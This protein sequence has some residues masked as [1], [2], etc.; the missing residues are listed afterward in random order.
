[1]AVRWVGVEQTWPAFRSVRPAGETRRDD[2]L[3][4]ELPRAG[5]RGVGES[6]S[7]TRGAFQ[8]VKAG[9]RGARSLLAVVRPSSP[10]FQRIAVTGIQGWTSDEH[11][12]E[13]AE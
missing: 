6:T 8:S 11:P 2:D 4:H 5:L 7:A 12:H 3:H 9:A 1:L 10:I 13:E